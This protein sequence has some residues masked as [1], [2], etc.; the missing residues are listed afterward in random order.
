M[1]ERAIIILVLAGILVL[2]INALSK[3]RA[4]RVEWE[5]QFTGNVAGFRL[6]HENTPVCET[7]D[8][9]AVSME[10]TLNLPDG[11]A[12]FTLTTVF[13]DGT[14]SP[15]SPVF[16]Y[17]FSSELVAA[18]TAEP[19]AGNTPLAVAFDAT[20]SKGNIL[21]YDW[22]FGDGATGAGS[23]INHTFFSAGDYTA[24]LKITDTIGATDRET[25]S[26]I[27]TTP[28]TDN[29][30]PLAV[31]SSSSS[32]G[33]APLPV[34]FDGS[35]STDS[36]GSILA[37][38]WD[39]GD[40]ETATGTPV[41]NTYLTAGTFHA[42]LTVT[43]NGGLTDSTS[44]PVLV[45]EPAEG[46]NLPPTA[47]ISASTSQGPAPLSVTFDAGESSDPDGEIYSYS[48]SF[49][50]GTNA[51]GILADHIYIQPGVYTVRLKVT[52]TMGATAEAVY[53]VTVQAGSPES[54]LVVE[55]G[56]TTINSTWSR[57][58]LTKDFV[59]PIVIVGP[60]SNNDSDP[61]IVRIRNADTTGFDIR[62]QEWDYLDDVH[63]DETVHYLVM[64][65]GLHTLD[66]GARIEAG[67]FIGGIR[68]QALKF[69][70]PFPTEPVVLTTVSS[71]NEEDA[72]TGRIRKL[73]PDGFEYKLSEQEANKFA[74][75]DETIGYIAWEPGAGS[76]D[77]VE[78]EAGK[79]D[80]SV[81]GQWQIIKF[82]KQ[83]TGIPLFFADMQ[84]YNSGENAAVRY[85]DLTA[86]DVFVKI[87]EE[88]S[89][90]SETDHTSERVGYINFST[91]TDK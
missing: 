14:E 90:D 56:S 87:E 21:N 88:A 45:S 55:L 84:T 20:T 62:I 72:V 1:K 26:I 35:G 17:I 13:Q 36:D 57:V 43:D 54:V 86:T 78:Y 91:V 70:M 12:F 40:G 39:M 32:V 48:W 58:V 15:H 44:T 27:A 71:V 74:H 23:S 61:C 10:C 22:I 2:S 11:K 9:N 80:N 65:Q 77:Q 4:I 52:D 18:M 67:A 66:N 41:E 68:F 81:T 79:T 82:N 33:A 5:Y 51:A 46:S 6:Y 89:K 73:S 64:E 53:T 85:Q 31:I 42:A 38:D 25:V 76:I 19:L 59:N 7:L 8:S 28:S 24:T 16:S 37:F 49:G 83:F 50:D 29:T 34:Q 60:P 47:A 69:Q 75:A 63:A 30:P 3:P